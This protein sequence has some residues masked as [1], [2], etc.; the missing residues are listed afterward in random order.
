LNSGMKPPVIQVWFFAFCWIC[1]MLGAAH[2]AAATDDAASYPRV[3]VA[4][5]FIELHTGA[6]KGYPVYHVVDRHEWVEVLVRQGDWFKVRDRLGKEGWVL[7]DEMEKT[8]SAPGVTTQFERI[9]K[10]HFGARTYEG[11]IN[12]G[13]FEGSAIMGVY[14]GLNFNDNLATELE[15]SKATGQFTETLVARI[16]ILS[17]PFPTWDS[18]PF[19]TLGGG[20][21]RNKPKSSFVFANPTS[22]LFASVGL[23]Y[24]QYMSKRVFFRAD[25]KQNIVFISDNNNGDFLEWKIGFSF[26]Y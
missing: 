14:A 1:M 22:D 12:F 13:D 16:N 17:N 8:L 11:G 2:V 21:M 26:F 4:E 24:R 20:Y 23:G 19:F 5:P 9:K 7:I 18:A 25:V 3:I 15:I 6:G 10:E